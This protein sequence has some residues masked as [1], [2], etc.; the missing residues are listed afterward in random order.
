[1]SINVIYLQ[2]KAIITNKLQVM[3]K[4]A[5]KPF[6]LSLL[7]LLLLINT[8]AL[9]QTS[10]KE[11]AKNIEKL[12]LHKEAIDFNA[13]TESY[14]HITGNNF[15]QPSAIGGNIVGIKNINE[16]TIVQ[17]RGTNPQGGF[18]PSGD[19]KLFLRYRVRTNRGYDSIYHVIHP[20]HLEAG[21]SY[22]IRYQPKKRQHYFEEDP[23]NRVEDFV[24]K[25]ELIKS[26]KSYTEA[27]PKRLDGAW[28]AET[29]RLMK[30]FFIK[31]DIQGDKISF[32]SKSKNAEMRAIIGE[33]RLFYTENLIMMFP[34]KAIANGKEYQNFNN[35]PIYVWSYTLTDGVLNIEGGRLFVNGFHIWEN[36]GSFRKTN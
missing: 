35:E 17:I 11:A 21:K 31:Y 19:I 3:G 2:I 32:E 10:A 25:L 28:T 23:T 26:F 4:L 27:N 5:Q 9:A 22:E 1:M 8:V 14:C 16:N 7:A 29:K 20:C 33:G 6:R 12:G 24:N 30:T 36:T 15:I 34:E 13:P 18:I